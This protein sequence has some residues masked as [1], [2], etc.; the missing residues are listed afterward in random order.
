MH[1]GWNIWQGV[2]V[3]PKEVAARLA[4]KWQSAYSV[5]MNYVRV[6]LQFALIRAVEVRIRRSRKR[7]HGTGSMDGAWGLCLKVNSWKISSEKTKTK[8]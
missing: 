5:V 1:R 3:F 2:C 7:I 4:T 6:K 8:K